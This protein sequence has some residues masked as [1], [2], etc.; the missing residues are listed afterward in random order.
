MAREIFTIPLEGLKGFVTLEHLKPGVKEEILGEIAIN[1]S[2]Q[3]AQLAQQMG[4]DRDHLKTAIRLLAGR[5]SGQ[6]HCP[7]FQ[8]IPD[9]QKLRLRP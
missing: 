2:I 9:D 4:C 1:S 3:V 5:R 7:T 8:E 6:I